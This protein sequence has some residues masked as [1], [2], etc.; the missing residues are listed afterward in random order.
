MVNGCIKLYSAANSLRLFRAYFFRDI[1]KERWALG[2][3]YSL[4]LDPRELKTS[5]S[6]LE[7]YNF[8]K[9]KDSFQ[10]SHIKK[11]ERSQKQHIREVMDWF[12]FPLLRITAG[13]LACFYFSQPIWCWGIIFTPRWNSSWAEPESLWT[14]IIS[15]V[16]TVVLTFHS[17]TIRKLEN[18]SGR[19][20]IPFHRLFFHSIMIMD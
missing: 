14:N 11:W 12:H 3:C 7:R 6:A 17:S 8:S 18:I 1:S 4:F 15:T 9:Q 2:M 16:I 13:W 20:P 19:K 10:S 5:D